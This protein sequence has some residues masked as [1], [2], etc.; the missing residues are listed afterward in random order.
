[1]EYGERERELERGGGGRGRERERERE[2]RERDST[3]YFC[4]NNYC[5]FCQP[6]IDVMSYML[7]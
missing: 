6:L 3:N 5:F 1:M 7:D 2:G 4:H